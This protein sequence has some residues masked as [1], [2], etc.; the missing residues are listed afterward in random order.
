C[1]SG[2]GSAGPPCPAAAASSRGPPTAAA[3]PGHAVPPVPGE[4]LPCCGL[5]SQTLPSV[6][7]LFSGFSGGSARLSGEKFPR[8][9]KKGRNRRA[10]TTARPMRWRKSLSHQ[11]ISNNPREDAREGACRS[12]KFS[13]QG[14]PSV[15]TL[16]M[17]QA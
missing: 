4:V 6:R 8:N 12:V 9:G 15:L 5:F 13:K 17:V 1:G 16:L 7:S 11:R 14:C 3:P 2:G 10:A